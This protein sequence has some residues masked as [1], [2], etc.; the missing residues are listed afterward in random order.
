[1]KEE[2]Q[3]EVEDLEGIA[4]NHQGHQELDLQDHYQENQVDLKTPVK[5]LH[6]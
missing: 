5:P 3:Q 2:L 1:M 6:L 4:G